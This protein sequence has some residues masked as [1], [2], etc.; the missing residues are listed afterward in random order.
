MD[1]SEP[2]AAL[3]RDRF[4]AFRRKPAPGQTLPAMHCFAGDTYAGLEAA[5]MGPDAMRWAE[6]HLR[7]LSGLYGLLRPLDAIQPY[8]LE[9]GSRLANPRGADLYA[10]WGDRIAKA[11]KAQAAAMGTRGSGQLRLG[12][13]FYGRQPQ[14]TEAAGDLA[15]FSGREGGR[16]QDRVVFC[17]EGARRDGALSVRPPPD[18]PRRSARAFDGRLRLPRRSV[19]R[20]D[21][22]VFSRCAAARGRRPDP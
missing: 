16:G 19:G 3:N 18:R 1:L 15:G 9:M 13:I 17:Q 10:F 7:I 8:R 5:T 20:A 6:G 22:L 12:R 21:R 4:A 14:G 2:L 11:L